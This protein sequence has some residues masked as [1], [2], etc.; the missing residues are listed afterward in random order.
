[1]RLPYVAACPMFSHRTS[2]AQDHT[3]LSDHREECMSD[4]YEFLRARNAASGFT[5]E[6]V[7][8]SFLPLLRQ[9]IDC[10]VN[11]FVAPL[12]GLD[13]LQVEGP[14]IWFEDARRLPSK[15]NATRL[16]DLLAEMS[17]GAAV[18]V[19]ERSVEFER[20]DDQETFIDLQVDQNGGELTRPIYLPRFAAWEHRIGHHDPVTDVFSLGMI[21]ASLACGFDF[22][23]ATDLAEFVEHRRNL[24]RSRPNLH[25]LLARTIE[26]M[27]ELDRRDRSTDLASIL[28]SLQD[29]GQ[30]QVDFQLELDSIEGFGTKDLESKHQ[31]V[32]A[33][34]QQRLFQVSRR[35]RLLHFRTTMQTVNLT[36]ASVPLS[37]DYKNIRPEQ[38]MTWNADFAAQALQG[39]QIPL[40]KYLNFEE[41]IYLPIVLDRIRNESRRDQ[42]EFG[43]SQIR[44][45]ACFL[46][47]TNTKVS[48]VESYHSPLA[49]LPVQLTRKKGV[50][51]T[52]QLRLLSSIAEIN[53]VVRHQFKQ[54]YAIELPETIDLDESDF[55]TFYH[56]LRSQVRSSEPA[57]EIELIDKPR[58]SLLHDKARRRLD[59]YRRR[60][61][62]SGRGVRS[63]LDLDYSYDPANYH[64]LGVKVFSAMVRPAETRLNAIVEEHSRPPA[65][66]TAPGDADVDPDTK[67]RSFFQLRAGDDNP[68]HWE[69]D[70][71]SMTLG[72]F[73][74]R[75][76]SL[77]R[78]YDAVADQPIDNQAFD[79][80]FALS[81]RPAPMEIETPDLADR[82]HV[83]PCD[84]TQTLSI[85]QAKA[86]ASYIIQGPPGTGKSQTITNLIADF[87]ARGK[88]VLFVCEKR[89]AI[90]VVYLRLKQQGLDELCCL[91]HD[92]QQDKKQ[93][94]MDLKR[95]YE[96]FLERERK[97]MS[98][99]REKLTTD[100][101]REI[102]PLELY[103]SAMVEPDEHDVVLLDVIQ[104]AVRLR[105]ATPKLSSKE[106]EQAP[107]YAQWR[108]NLESIGRFKRSLQEVT[109]DGVFA[110]HPLNRFSTKLA[111]LDRPLEM[112]A[113][114]LQQALRHL[115]ALTERLEEAGF[116][117]A[118]I[119]TPKQ[120]RSA[121]KLCQQWRSLAQ[122]DLLAL[123]DPQ[124]DVSSDYEDSR[125]H[126]RSLETR[127]L[128]TRE[129]NCHWKNKLKRGETEDALQ[130]AKQLDGKWWSR[131]N[132]AWWRL[133]G[134]LKRCYSFDAH[135]IQPAWR[136][137]LQRL[138]QEHD[139]EEAL[140]KAEEDCAA[141]F[142][143][144]DYAPHQFF[145]DVEKLRAT[146]DDL[147]DVDMR[148]FADALIHSRGGASR[149]AVI[150]RAEEHR[151]A[152]M[153]ACE[154]VIEDL[155]NLS[156]EELRTALIQ[157]EQA[158]NEWSSFLDCL[159]DLDKLPKDLIDSFRNLPL[160]LEQIEAAAAQKHIE[161]A[162]RE[163]NDAG[164]FDSAA[165]N[166]HANRL[167]EYYDDWLAANAA[168][169]KRRIARQFREK[170]EICDLPASKLTPEQ[171]EFKNRYER[172]R[173]ILKHEFGKS[174]RYKSIRDLVSDNSGE[175]VK[176][177]KPVWLMSPLSVSD[178]VPLDQDHFDV[179]IFDEASQITL[180][181]AVPTIFRAT[182]AIVVG[183][184]MQ[185]PP[186]DFFSAKR[187]EE[188][189]LLIE[190]D[191]EMVE[192]DLDSDSLL[193][194]SS[195]NLPSTMLGWHYRSRSESL[196]SFSN[197]S[198]Y[199]GKLLTVPEE[200]LPT[201]R[202]PELIV[203]SAENSVE[204]AAQ[205]A[206]RAV[207]FHFVENGVYHKRRNRAEADYIAHLVRECISADQ[208]FS[209]GVV[210][211]SEAQ[212]D[213]IESALQRLGGT[214]PQFADRLEQE[215]EREEEDGQFAGLL[216]KNLE[217]IQGDE[218]D[219]IIMSVCYGHD[220]DGK[221]RMNFGPI[222]RQGG[223]KRLNVAFS[224][225]K[226]RMVLVSSIRHFDITNDYNVGANCL[227]RYL[228]YAERISIGDMDG[229]QR[230][231]EEIAVVRDDH[232]RDSQGDDAIANEIASRL[233]KEGFLVEFG[234]G[235]S[236]FRCDLAIRREGDSTYRLGIRL[237]TQDY[238]DDLD[239]LERELMKPKLLRDFGWN[240]EVILAKDWQA[241]PDSILSHLLE[242]LEDGPNG[243]FA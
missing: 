132:P 12:D 239:P 236:Q 175:V 222:N 74:Y 185:L 180:E 86:E 144:R 37:F 210:A 53:P 103:R 23:D 231:L 29:F 96:R 71:C 59:A 61:R 19:T 104:H 85:G 83:V 80:I 142:G 48:P 101:A 57:I 158:E 50:R 38:L 201:S 177:L 218:R 40:D 172:G 166:R 157:I 77:V 58:I 171:K 33:K 100:L 114:A 11:G 84:P 154:N 183:D 174:M 70:L 94:V 32:L 155:A 108:D 52:Y 179:V 31:I 169:V 219:V 227:K 242:R 122:F 217:N 87:V 107:A 140:R 192:Y 82:F 109:T 35:N 139:A 199:G 30:Q 9:V 68:F 62:V 115:Q 56:Y 34:L 89:A 223:E 75:K 16:S 208:H 128:D 152:M 69:F 102:R 204:H 240:V 234:V 18:V 220:A 45:V 55:E 21:L 15:S 39:E 191:G 193:T 161:R 4:F 230:V 200:D 41:A 119:S 72:N 98:A 67:S 26:R 47:W 194:H 150:E 65:Y 121:A 127:L 167:E 173:K 63:Y 243:P 111:R 147:V 137:V 3:R 189:V 197:W 54:L 64:P 42:A 221:M 81:P 164:R 202:R 215:L 149:V 237:D 214:D 136:D 25:P 211:F 131:L 182:Q 24:F 5:T 176:D 148:T 88:R 91:I 118:A 146:L 44:L 241:D 79:G 90:D 143:I 190:D 138:L 205:I 232:N 206:D 78:D 163:D 229:A 181:E 28:N 60:A 7:L 76:M 106:L 203:H 134:V 209:I 20:D 129:Q 233:L 95:T 99:E 225:A 162:F 8:V 116:D 93:F 184:E 51:D 105:D 13:A 170:I 113:N 228:R 22:H 2:H 110:S 238:Y 124:S 195:R 198:F 112:I 10:H 213:E 14:R 188:D 145:G 168:E 66:A 186:T 97:S 36:E 226:H 133:R 187:D 153:E 46:R 17:R 160:E 224:R 73:R 123:L 141:A 130:Q 6:D 216:I 159:N 235:Q 27:T 156:W 1:M 120:L 135:S 126:L 125:I 212:Q 43:F 117:S 49:L 92:S 165:R 207:S 196:I 178:T 151:G